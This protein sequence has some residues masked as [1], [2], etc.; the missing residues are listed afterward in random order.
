MFPDAS[1]KFPLYFGVGAGLGVFVKQLSG[2]SAMSLDYQVLAGARFFDLF[3]NAGFFLEAGLKNH[4]H[5]LSD[6]QFNGTFVA[7]GSVFTF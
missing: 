1:S 2:E 6:G 3:N 4:M 7:A 5:M